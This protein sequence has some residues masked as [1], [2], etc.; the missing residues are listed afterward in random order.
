[1]KRGPVSQHISR[2]PI[3]GKKKPIMIACTNDEYKKKNGGEIKIFV[4]R[5]QE[6]GKKMIKIREERGKKSNY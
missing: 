6:K 2:T 5:K 4:T 3:I 1:M